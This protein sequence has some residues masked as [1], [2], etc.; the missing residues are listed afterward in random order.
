MIDVYH[1]LELRSQG[2]INGDRYRQCFKV[3][4][5]LLED[6]SAKPVRNLPC[7]FSGEPRA[8]FLVD[9]SPN[10]LRVASTH[11]DH[12]VRVTDIRTGKCSHILT[13]HPRT[14]WCLAFNPTS[15][16]ILASGC[17]GGE[18]RI[19]DLLGG[20]SEVLRNPCAGQVITSLAFHPSGEVLVFAAMN[21]IYFWDWSKNAPFT[22]TQTAHEYERIR[23]LR[24]DPFGQY[25]YTGIANNTTV[26]RERDLSTSQGD[27]P[28]DLARETS[29][30]SSDERNSQQMNRMRYQSLLQRFMAYQHDRHS[31]VYVQNRAPRSPVHEEG[32]ESAREY[33]RYMTNLERNLQLRSQD[34]YD[35]D[36]SSSYISLNP[37]QPSTSRS[38]PTAPD[39]SL[40]EQ[41]RPLNLSTVPAR[42]DDAQSSRRWG[43][44]E[45]LFFSRCPGVNEG[46]GENSNNNNLNFGTAA[47]S[48]YRPDDVPVR[49]STTSDR[50]FTVTSWQTPEEPSLYNRS[51]ETPGSS[52][53]SSSFHHVSSQVR[54]E[55]AAS[56]SLDANEFEIL[57]V[58]QERESLRRVS[59]NGSSSSGTL[60]NADASWEDLRSL[61]NRLGHRS[62]DAPSESS[63]AAAVTGVAPPCLVASS[64]SAASTAEGNETQARL[65]SLRVP[66]APASSA[67]CLPVQSHLDRYTGSTD[68]SLPGLSSEVYSANRT[69]I[70]P[71]PPYTLPSRFPSHSSRFTRPA[72]QNSILGRME[73]P[74]PVRPDI[75]PAPFRFNSSSGHSWRRQMIN[76]HHSLE[77]NEGSDY[78]H[79]SSLLD[80]SLP[81]H[82][83][84]QTSQTLGAM[85]LPASSDQCTDVAGLG[86]QPLAMENLA[87]LQ[88]RRNNEGDHDYSYSSRQDR[89]IPNI[90]HVVEDE[91]SGADHTYVRQRTG[92]RSIDLRN[93]DDE[94][95]PDS[96]FQS[97]SFF[98]GYREGLN[99][100][101]SSEN[102]YSQSTSMLSNDLEVPTD[103]SEGRDETDSS[104]PGDGGD[105]T[106]SLWPVNSPLTLTRELDSLDVLNGNSQLTTSNSENS[107]LHTGSNFLGDHCE[108]L[109]RNTCRTDDNRAGSSCRKVSS[110]G[111]SEGL[112][113][114]HVASRDN[115]RSSTSNG[116]S[117]A[118]SNGIVLL[119]LELYNP[120]RPTSVDSLSSFD[121]STSKPD[122]SEAARSKNSTTSSSF[123][124]ILTQD[125]KSSKTTAS[126]SF[127]LHPYTDQPTGH[128]N[129]TRSYLDRPSSSRVES[130]TNRLR[131]RLSIM[132]GYH[133]WPPIGIV[134]HVPVSCRSFETGTTS[135]T[136][137]MHSAGSLPSGTGIGPNGD[138]GQ[139]SAFSVFSASPR[140]TLR[141]SAEPRASSFHNPASANPSAPTVYG[142]HYQP[143]SQQP[144]SSIPSRIDNV[145]DVQERLQQAVL[146]LREVQSSV[147]ELSLGSHHCLHLPSSNVTEYL[148]RRVSE[149]DRRISDLENNYNSRI[150]VL[151]HEFLMRRIQ[152]RDRRRQ[153]NENPYPRARS[154]TSVL[155]EAQEI[156]L[157]ARRMVADA[158]GVGVTDDDR[159]T[160]RGDA[161]SA[162]TPAPT[163]AAPFRP[164]QLL[165]CLSRPSSS[166]APNALPARNP[167]V[168][169]SRPA[170][171]QPPREAEREGNSSGLNRHNPNLQ[172]LH[173]DYSISILDNSIN[174][175]DESVQR[176]FN[177]TIAGAF[178]SRDEIAVA[179]NIVPQTHR[180]QR[181]DVSKCVVPNITNATANIIVKH[182]KLHNDASCD[183]SKDGTLL[184]TFVSNHSGF[185]DNNILAV[186]S[187][188]HET[189]AQCL[190]TKS[191]GP[192]AISVSISPINRYVLVGL[193]AKRFFF[194]SVNQMVAQVYK[195]ERQKAGENSMKHITDMFHPLQQELRNHVSVNSA[196][197][198][199]GIGEGMVYGTNRGDLFFCRPGFPV[200]FLAQGR[201]LNQNLPNIE[202][203]YL[204]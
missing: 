47:Q 55:N 9:F 19:W 58:D 128:E 17:L 27:D 204:D 141:T 62:T 167:T 70:E 64:S 177:R 38:S 114:E 137:P 164:Q 198:L 161:P 57:P 116:T 146:Q 74:P 197:W 34:N 13:G 108:P 115:V 188:R 179:S 125:G 4:K 35:D 65:A 93:E 166:A 163:P 90:R 84:D 79:H 168:A 178:L 162:P 89:S 97:H 76:R 170:P 66:P 107:L 36:S 37:S 183:M 1:Y 127:Q 104:I 182:C 53:A 147:R 154:F 109:V 180:I 175:P 23:W 158:H 44:Y 117:N 112:V 54:N 11:G 30:V 73:R 69:H 29:G 153:A 139:R 46:S 186:F 111:H 184:V 31:R 196:R 140:D 80:R 185:P 119:G 12:T 157:R 60:A 40:S 110:C 50:P 160:P 132:R 39:S 45:P 159:I 200:D 118:T 130:R 98:G 129:G 6:V 195:L 123:N 94:A 124:A 26:H 126:S 133:P 201:S 181:W 187:L 100:N 48:T 149:L 165:Q 176:L 28:L 77:L 143:S 22:C 14:P 85:N 193:A 172:H 96:T 92:V 20:G 131:R 16:D 49:S 2:L 122:S 67:R 136:V 81:R 169:N 152:S 72:E 68:S 135:N 121:C 52:A 63:G 191:F 203:H 42:Q 103:C 171:A 21:T 134:S 99:N 192:N 8:T 113:L 41:S 145:R 106:P 43:R 3:V 83:I 86:E 75:P 88:S 138:A 142:I 5:D 173:P 7:E 33:A 87:S 155:R 189:L 199:P 190:Y 151:G 78:S 91:Q 51:S 102:L 15:N 174:R 144:D 105:C 194:S 101:L 82:V 156:R 18:V 10:M 32:L 59:N 56:E 24:F 202:E 71:E 25:L 148:E 150:R 95:L 120:E 61:L